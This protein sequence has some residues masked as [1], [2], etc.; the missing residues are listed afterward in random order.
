MSSQTL[1]L[2]TSILLSLAFVTYW[3]GRRYNF[4]TDVPSLETPL[5]VPRRDPCI[6]YR[7]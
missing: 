3:K 4:R 6:E 7:V 2:V 5:D 1:D